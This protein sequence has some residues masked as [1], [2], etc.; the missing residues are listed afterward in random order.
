MSPP[1][2]QTQ[3]S[4]Q[5]SSPRDNHS[6]VTNM[7]INKGTRIE[8]EIAQ[9]W[10][11]GQSNIVDL[12]KFVPNKHR[13][14]RSSR[15]AQNKEVKAGALEDIKELWKCQRAFQYSDVV[16]QRENFFVPLFKWSGLSVVRSKVHIIV[17]YPYVQVICPVKLMAGGSHIQKN[18]LTF[19]INRR[20]YFRSL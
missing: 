7:H 19:P 2:S 9:R 18:T 14:G 8:Y 20:K 4:A 15:G 3:R 17:L 1:L 10:S 6:R 5:E 11:Q 13:G 12:R 16:L